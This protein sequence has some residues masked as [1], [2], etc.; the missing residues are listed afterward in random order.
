[1][2]W[3]LEGGGCRE[4]AIQ[5]RDGM[6]LSKGTLETHNVSIMCLRVVVSSNLDSAL[7]KTRLKGMSMCIS[8]QQPCDP[9]ARAA[10]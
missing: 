4:V 2:L 3:M 7:N 6:C 9:E 8:A 5:S 1:M 10:S